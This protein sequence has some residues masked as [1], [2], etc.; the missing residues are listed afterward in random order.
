MANS[1]QIRN[2]PVLLVLGGRERFFKFDMNAFVELENKYG[3][4]DAAMKA[5]EGGKMKDML[6]V[7]WAGFIHDEAVLDEVT[8]EPI[9]Y[10]ITPYSVG[11]WMEEPSMLQEASNALAV[12]MGASLPENEGKKAAK[13]A[14]P[15]QLLP[16]GAATVVYTE[17]ES[18]QEKNS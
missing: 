17:E 2:K 6:Y 8:G 7:M 9:K 5:L 4:V 15:Q 11:R 16:E 10:N 13:K 12:A 1:K 3:S 18:E 14:E